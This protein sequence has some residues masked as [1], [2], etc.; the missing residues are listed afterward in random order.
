MSTDHQK[1]AK[2]GQIRNHIAAGNALLEKPFDAK[3]AE[4]WILACTG[5]NEQ[6]KLN[7]DDPVFVT[8]GNSLTLLARRLEARWR[9]EQPDAE[10]MSGDLTSSQEADDEQSDGEDM[11]KSVNEISNQ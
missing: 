5:L 9:Q 1:L 2:L 3:A 7:K 8:L 10:A 6:V 4:Q 11:D